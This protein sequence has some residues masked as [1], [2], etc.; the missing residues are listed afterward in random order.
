[1]TGMIS[2]L[3]SPSLQIVIELY[4]LLE[5]VN[6]DGQPMYHVDTICDFLYPLLLTG[7][8][9]GWGGVGWVKCLKVL[10]T[11]RCCCCC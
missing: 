6:R 9:V 3:F 1:M 4:H 2:F 10:A 8:G 5:K 11:F 7:G